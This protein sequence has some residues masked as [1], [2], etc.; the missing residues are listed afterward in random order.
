MT[1]NRPENL[2]DAL[3]RPG[4]VDHQVA[5][6]NA[7]QGQIKELFER[8]YANELPRTRLQPLSSPTSPTTSQLLDEKISPRKELTP[9]ATPTT[10]GPMPLQSSNEAANSATNGK[11]LNAIVEEVQ[12]EQLSR[13]A[14]RFAEKIP[15]GLFSPAELQGF[16]LKRKKNPRKACEEVG[17]WVDAMLEVKRVGGKLVPQ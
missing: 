8:M 17:K 3:I 1:T 5:F 7:T 6:N 2:D 13:L 10:T 15:D 14:S 4:R 9:P 11:L 16:L 12:G